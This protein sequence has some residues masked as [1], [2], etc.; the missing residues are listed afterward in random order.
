MGVAGLAGPAGLRIAGSALYSALRMSKDEPEPAASGG[1]KRLRAILK[2]VFLLGTP[3]LVLFSIFAG[4]V[5]CGASRAP[6]VVGF[7]ERWLG[8]DPPE[9]FE[10]PSEDGGETGGETEG[11]AE[12]DETGGETEGDAKPDDDAKDPKPDDEG[13]PVAE[14][15]PAP[16]ELREAF[17]AE[18]IVELKIL[19][20]P[21]LLT[22][23]TDWLDYVQTL[24]EASSLSF[25]RLF[26][27]ELRL[28]GVV[29]WE[30]VGADPEL[31]LEDLA[32][33]EREG[34]DVIV[35]LVARP[36]PSGFTAP[37]WQ[38]TENGGHAL[39]FAN[40]EHEDRYYRGLLAGLAQLFG[41]EPVNDPQSPAALRGSFMSGAEVEADAPPWIDP[42]NREV[43]IANKQRDF[44]EAD[45]KVGAAP[46][47]ETEEDE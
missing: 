22:T 5:Y 37:R 38:G 19:V 1:G 17:G 2:L 23:R 45:A 47:S 27:I 36:R 15:I 16:E 43:V 24:V 30:A 29:V 39:V 42:K 14:R 44:A 10:A 12:A 31:L 25:E 40:V 7:E 46:N 34:A 26:G 20:D 4:G 28:H 21:A 3:V 18:R 41:A 9:G 32:S 8:I 13:L 11:E 33:H 6:A 35:G